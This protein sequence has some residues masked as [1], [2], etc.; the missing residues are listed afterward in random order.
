[1]NLKFTGGP[2][3]LGDFIAIA[4]SN[5]FTLGWY[6]GTGRGTV[7]Y[8]HLHAPKDTHEYYLD[9]TSGKVNN[10]YRRKMFKD[11]FTHKSIWKAYV[12]SPHGNRII[13]LENPEA[14]LDQETLEVYNKSR[15]A[16]IEVKFI[17]P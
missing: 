7:Q 3:Q 15:E 12:N 4:Y 5:G 9:F 8:Y 16:L 10:P 2:L 1:M 6:A 17:Q 11:G 13:K 14:I